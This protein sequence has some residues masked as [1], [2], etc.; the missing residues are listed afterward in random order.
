MNDDTWYYM[1]MDF[2]EVYCTSCLA[3]FYFM[4]GSCACGVGHY[5]VFEEEIGSATVF[6]KNVF[7]LS[8]SMTNGHI[9][10]QHEV[11]LVNV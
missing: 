4:D 7:L 1:V 8:S 6:P 2:G 5:S 3:S 9:Y 10:E 11:K